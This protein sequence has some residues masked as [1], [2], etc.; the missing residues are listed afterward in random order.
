MSRP[1]IELPASRA[2]HAHAQ[3]AV[4]LLVMRDPAFL[5]AAGWKNPARH[6]VADDDVPVTADARMQNRIMHRFVTEQRDGNERRG[7]FSRDALL[8]RCENGFLE[9]SSNL[10]VALR[11]SVFASGGE[12]CAQV[13]DRAPGLGVCVEAVAERV[14]VAAVLLLGKQTAFA[15][16]II[17]EPFGFLLPTRTQLVDGC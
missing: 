7:R 11:I 17:D 16:A 4:P 10:G 5:L 8:N 3:S 1:E 15:C 2:Q 12:R 6:R 9:L 14:D 13:A